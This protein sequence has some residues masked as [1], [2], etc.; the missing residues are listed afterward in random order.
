MIDLSL[1]QLVLRLVA[2]AVIASVHGFAVAA[3][4]YALGDRGVA[5]DGRLRI[6]PLAHLDLVGTVAGVL[7]AIGWIKPIAIDPDEMR[8]G[9]LGLVLVVATGAAATLVAAVALRLLR[10]SLL[11]FLSDTASAATFA[12]IETFTELSL[13]F[14]LASLLPLP[15]F[16]GMHLLAAAAPG[17]RKPMARWQVP[18]GLAVA[19]LAALGAFAALLGPIY[20]TLAPAVLGAAP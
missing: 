3:T 5:H 8:T 16:T 20:R 4:A 10:P 14:A 9:R 13:W 7:F 11:P 19:V 1:D 17:W 2:Y 12:W 18:A 6:N 15:P